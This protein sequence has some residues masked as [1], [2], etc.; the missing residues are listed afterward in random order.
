MCEC[1]RACVC[2]RVCVCVC[3]CALSTTAPSTRSANTTSYGPLTPSGIDKN[4]SRTHKEPPPGKD[5]TGTAPM[6]SGE[7][8]IT[9]M[10]VCPVLRTGFFLGKIFRCCFGQKIL[11]TVSA[12]LSRPPTTPSSVLLLPHQTSPLQNAELPPSFNI[13]SDYRIRI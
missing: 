13:I 11:P 12:F 10:A 3:V 6:I 5:R 7:R 4:I 9:K 2:V 1:V 8:A